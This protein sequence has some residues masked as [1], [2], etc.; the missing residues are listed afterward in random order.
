MALLAGCEMPP[1]VLTPSH[2]TKSGDMLIATSDNPAL[3]A[4]GKL[5]DELLL[6][7]CPGGSCGIGQMNI[8]FPSLNPSDPAMDLVHPDRDPSENPSQQQTSGPLNYRLESSIAFEGKPFFNWG[9]FKLPFPLFV[10]EGASIT[11]YVPARA[12]DIIPW[13]QFTAGTDSE[14]CQA[15]TGACAQYR[16]KTF[17]LLAGNLM[18]PPGPTFS[19]IFLVKHHEEQLPDTT[20]SLYDYTQGPLASLSLSEDVPLVLVHVHIFV[21]NA[22]TNTMQ[23][24]FNV[25]DATDATKRAAA[26]LVQNQFD[27]SQV[28][29]VEEGSQPTGYANT[30]ELRAGPQADEFGRAEIESQVDGAFGRCGVALRLASVNFIRQSDGFEQS[31]GQLY[32]NS[33]V[34]DLWNEDMNPVVRYVRDIANEQDTLNPKGCD[35]VI[36]QKAPPGI[37]VFVTG[38]D[39]P[40]SGTLAITE[41]LGGAQIVLINGNAP[42]KQ[43]GIENTLAHEIT[44]AIGEPT[45]GPG[46]NSNIAE[47][48]ADRFANTFFPQRMTYDCPDLPETGPI[49][50]GGPGFMPYPDPALQSDVEA[51][52]EIKAAAKILASSV[53]SEYDFWPVELYPLIN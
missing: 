7:D 20:I 44:H 5:E 21:S 16:D 38:K 25:V 9:M 36:C 46:A 14:L 32:S 43:G 3:V 19:S 45:S 8:H 22:G 13:V 37:H 27:Y 29:V 52:S 31:V 1:Q 26:E 49:F 35:N 48:R 4:L 34:A 17:P 24:P 15:V 18:L 39:D 23:L 11:S 2:T 6:P 50:S 47:C 41:R 33:R 28:R 42:Q 12:S 10:A 30:T 40:Q 51:C 53:P